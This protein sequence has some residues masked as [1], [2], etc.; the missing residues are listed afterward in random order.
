[1]AY[2]SNGSN[3]RSYV[4]VQ[5]STPLTVGNDYCVSFKVSLA[6]YTYQAV[7]NIGLYFSNFNTL[8]VLN[9]Q[10]DIANT[11]GV[12]TD[13]S[14]WVTISGSFTATNAD[15]WIIIGN[16]D[17]DSN[18]TVTDLSTLGVGQSGNLGYYYIDDV[19]VEGLEE[20]RIGVDIGTQTGQD[21]TLI[22]VND[23]VTLTASSSTSSTYSW[24]ALSDPFD[25]LLAIPYF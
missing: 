2:D 3:C 13:Q 10:P 25:T 22:C 20:I 5:L 8:P 9:T 24:A 11:N 16:F 18:T 1:L 7:E 12:I 15:D 21:T 4:A 19:S 6:D 14:N 23:V 17:D